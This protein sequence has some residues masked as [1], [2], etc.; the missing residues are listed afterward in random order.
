MLRPLLSLW[1][2]GIPILTFRPGL[3]FRPTRKPLARHDYEFF[4][5]CGR[6]RRWGFR[7]FV[8]IQDCTQMWQDCTLSGPDI[9]GFW[10]QKYIF[11]QQGR[12]CKV[13]PKSS[14]CGCTREGSLG[15]IRESPAK[16]LV[17]RHVFGKPAFSSRPSHYCWKN[18]ELLAI[19]R[20]HIDDMRWF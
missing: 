11:F 5:P 13:A 16:S 6:K 15:G 2:G 7:H 19:S 17:G 12:N 14:L 8:L 18:L 9:V 3:I 20:L 10:A 4:F 1:I